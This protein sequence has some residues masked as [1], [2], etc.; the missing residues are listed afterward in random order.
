[1]LRQSGHVICSPVYMPDTGTASVMYIAY[2]NLVCHG[3]IQMTAAVN[4]ERAT[5]IY[6]ASFEAHISNMVFTAIYLTNMRNCT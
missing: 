2:V 5:H 4:T 6:M 3:D 1:M